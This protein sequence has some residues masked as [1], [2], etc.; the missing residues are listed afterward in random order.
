VFIN[1]KTKYEEEAKDAAN[2]S[3]LAKADAELFSEQAAISAREA[4]NLAF[5]NQKSKYEEEAK[6]AANTSEL[7]KA[8]AELL[9]QKER[10]ISK[11]AAISAREASDLVFI[12]QKSK[13]CE[14]EAKDAAN[15]SQ[16][17]KADAEL[18][19]E[20]AAILA[21]EASDLVFIDQKSK[22]EEEAKYAANTSQ[23]AKENAELLWERERLLWEKE[24]L[25]WEKERD[26]LL[27]EKDRDVSKLAALSASNT[28][29]TELNSK[30]RL[31]RV[32]QNKR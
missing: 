18:F 25:R 27:Q 32:D 31:N 2:A 10:D 9:W 20:Q 4:S 7:A 30:Q 12:N 6:V 15:A 21:R 17:A 22:Y 16:L 1:Q 19:S 13:Y 26:V 5:M 3:Q 8:N 23:L 29:D 14:E 24:R 28:S 11:Q